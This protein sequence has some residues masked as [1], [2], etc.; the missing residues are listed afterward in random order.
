M[1]F[2]V[3]VLPKAEDDIRNIANYIHEQSSKSAEAWLNAYRQARMRLADNAT[4]YGNAIE[5]EHFDIDVRQ[6][7]FKTKYGRVYR[8]LFTIIGEEVRIL[9][10]RGPGQAPVKPNELGPPNS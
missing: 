1:K 9:R 7:L 5:N 4:I 10:V 8:L 6:A 3:K 2:R